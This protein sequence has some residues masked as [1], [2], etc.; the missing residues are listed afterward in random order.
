[1]SK[2]AYNI[3]QTDYENPTVICTVKTRAEAEMLV[4]IINSI[5]DMFYHDIWRLEAELEDFLRTEDKPESEY[6]D[7]Q[8]E[9]SL[10]R[11][12]LSDILRADM[13]INDPRNHSVEIEEI[14][15]RDGGNWIASLKGRL[16]SSS[17]FKDKTES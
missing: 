8:D 9:L 7:I 16:E 5:I 15:L 14:K 2:K 10:K 12:E 17:L 3:Y 4:P 13:W 1:M 6:D 11:N